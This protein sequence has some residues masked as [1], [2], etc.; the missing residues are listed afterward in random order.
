MQP[1]R[2]SVIVGIALQKSNA[3]EGGELSDTER[4]TFLGV[5]DMVQGLLIHKR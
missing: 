3:N 4:A 1:S 2:Q 5:M